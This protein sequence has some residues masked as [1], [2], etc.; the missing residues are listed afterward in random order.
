MFGV[1]RFVDQGNGEVGARNPAPA[2]VVFHQLV[3]TDT[4]C[5]RALAVSEVLWRRCVTPLYIRHRSQVLEHEY[6]SLYLHFEPL[7]QE[8]LRQLVCVQDAGLDDQAA[9]STNMDQTSLPG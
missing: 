9:G 3:S 7:G 2:A 6:L 5:A 1:L 8:D 4:K